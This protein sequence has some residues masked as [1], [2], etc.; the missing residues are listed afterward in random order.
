[1][2]SARSKVRWSG[3]TRYAASA[4]SLTSPSSCQP[5]AAS[6]S[7]GPLASC[8]TLGALGSASQA[9]S[10][11]S[12]SGVTVAA[13]TQ[14]AEPSAAARATERT[15]PVP[16]LQVPCTVTPTRSP[17]W[18]ASQAATASGSSTTPD[19]SKPDSSIS[20]SLSD[21]TVSKSRSR[22]TRNSSPSKS[23]C[24]S[25]RSHGCI[26]RRGGVDRKVEV[27]DQ[28]VE[29]PVAD[30]VAEVLAQ[31]LA[32]LAGDLVGVGDDAVEAV[33]LVDPPGREAGADARD[34]RQVVGGL[35][36]DRGQLGIAGR[37]H[38]VLRLDGRRRHPRQLGDAPAGVEHGHLVGDEL[39]R[40][41]VAAAGS[42]PRG[43]RSR[44]GWRAWR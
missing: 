6:A 23:V 22:S 1:M 4:V 41:A 17:A 3:L 42:G 26:A 25:W 11:A 38:A 13:S 35:A 9:P 16:D 19:I 33:V 7:S 27:G 2:R 14:A 44:P 5:R 34:T 29:S 21:W 32:L 18:S 36:H 20:S 31:R 43:R 40:V 39:E 15:S 8:M 28:R 30:H 37:W 12:S 24:T 10:A